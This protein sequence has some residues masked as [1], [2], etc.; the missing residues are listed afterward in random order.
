MQV[1]TYVSQ[2]HN[3]VYHFQSLMFVEKL[4]IEK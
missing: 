1:V 3:L 4:H 2:C